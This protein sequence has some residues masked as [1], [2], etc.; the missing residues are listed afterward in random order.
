[1]RA[2]SSAARS[3]DRRRRRRWRA[4]P[5]AATPAPSNTS[6]SRRPRNTN[7]AMPTHSDS[8]PRTTPSAMRPRNPVVSRQSCQSKYMSN[9]IGYAADPLPMSA[10]VRCSRSPGSSQQGRTGRKSS[11]NC[12]RFPRNTNRA[13]PTHSDSIP[14]ATP[15]AMRPRNPTVNVQASSVEIHEWGVD[16]AFFRTLLAAE[17]HGSCAHMAPQRQP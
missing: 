17:W 4:A 16:S 13:M 7:R 15:S 1:M 6:T 14:R 10:L 9:Y 5:T 8:I 2:C 3:D 11:E 12:A